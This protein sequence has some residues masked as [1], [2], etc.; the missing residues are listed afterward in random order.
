MIVISAA[1]HYM[2]SLDHCCLFCIQAKRRLRTDPDQFAGDDL[3]TFLIIII[4]ARLR[5]SMAFTTFRCLRNEM[6]KKP[7]VCL[8]TEVKSISVGKVAHETFEEHCV[9]QN[10]QVLCDSNTQLIRGKL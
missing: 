5:C 2:Y 7:G 4:Y 6:N 1:F 10:N 8:P 3:R 9:T